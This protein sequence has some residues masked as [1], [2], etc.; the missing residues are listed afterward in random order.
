M[1]Y[2]I[3]SNLIHILFHLKGAFLQHIQGETGAKVT[4]RGKGSGFI[5]PTGG[6][7]MEPMHVHLQ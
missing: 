4:L 3:L 1:S 6:E 7:A 2:I 5:E